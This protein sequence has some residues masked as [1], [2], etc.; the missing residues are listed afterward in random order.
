MNLYLFNPDNDLALANNDNNYHSPASARKMGADLTPLMGWLGNDGDYLL[1][2]EKVKWNFQPP[3]YPHLK[4][5]SLSDLK[6][7]F[8]KDKKRWTNLTTARVFSKKN[9]ISLTE[10]RDFT[11]ELPERFKNAI[12]KRLYTDGNLLMPRQ[13]IPWGWNHSLIQQL[14]N[15]GLPAFLLPSESRMLMIKEVSHRSLAVKVLKLIQERAPIAMKSLLCGT[16]QEIISEEELHSLIEKAPTELLLKSPLSGSGRGLIR[17]TGTYAH[18]ISGW[19]KNTLKTQ[20]S[21]ILEPYYNKVCDFAMEFLADTDRNIHFKGYS[22][23]ETNTHGSYTRNILLTD[24]AIISVLCRYGFPQQVFLELQQ[25]LTTILGAVIKDKRYTGYLGVDMM[26][27]RDKNGL[28]KIHPCVEI[29]ARF[30]MG[31]FSRLFYDR[32]ISPETTG[33]FQILFSKK[34]GDLQEHIKKEADK[35]PLLIKDNRFISGYLPLTPMNNST[36]FLAEVNL[37]PLSTLRQ[38]ECQD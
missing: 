9:E 12:T 19:C 29:N 1:F 14:G 11:K 22:L 35:N 23:F 32:Y 30:T 10:K 2:P 36:Q 20:G 8:I 13:V 4:A 18:P 37:S 38:D 33:T 7:E 16:S 15:A 6:E 34:E 28:Y 31:V 5:C 3:L 24:T 25:L 26:I 27:C 21:V 17:G